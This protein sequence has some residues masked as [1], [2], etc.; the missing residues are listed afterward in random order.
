M[1]YDSN[2]TFNN[3]EL[4]SFL[5]LLQCDHPQI[6]TN[7]VTNYN[8]DSVEHI[9]FVLNGEKMGAHWGAIRPNTCD[10]LLVTQAICI[11]VLQLEKPECKSKL[12]VL[13]YFNKFH[14]TLFMGM[15]NYGRGM[16]WDYVSQRSK[17]VYIFCFKQDPYGKVYKF[18][19]LPKTTFIWQ[20]SNFPY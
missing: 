6:Q 10:M 13:F 19:L 16:M 4:W 17:Y 8:I 14:S 20:G 12:F 1:Y 3:D 2:S 7:W 9:A 18:L 11:H 15:A 5:K